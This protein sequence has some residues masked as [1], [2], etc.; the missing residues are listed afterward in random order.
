MA[1]DAPRD[2][3]PAIDGPARV[4]LDPRGS[5]GS[6]LF[7]LTVAPDQARPGRRD[8]T[9]D[10]DRLGRLDGGQPGR[11]DEQRRQ[12]VRV[13]LRD[14]HVG[15][16]DLLDEFACDRIQ[17]RQF[18]LHRLVVGEDVPT[19]HGCG[20]PAAR[21]IA[22]RAGMRRFGEHAQS[23]PGKT[24]GGLLDRGD[25]VLLVDVVEEELERVVRRGGGDDGEQSVSVR[26]VIGPEGQERKE[27]A[28]DA[29]EGGPQ[30]CGFLKDLAYVHRAPRDG[31]EGGYLLRRRD[32]AERQPRGHVIHPRPPAAVGEVGLDPVG[33]LRHQ[34][35]GERTR[36]RVGQRRGGPGR[37]IACQD[38][39]DL[40]VVL[41]AR[42]HQMPPQTDREVETPPRF[43]NLLITGTL[44]HEAP[45]VP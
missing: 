16:A 7:S 39:A 12:R 41:L 21:R 42:R 23:A 36:K 34:E 25:V 11:A 3:V 9:G 13:R 32:R 19:Q 44:A 45:R 40:R 5:P 2:V 26:Q 30:R 27:T 35:G 17:V 18:G 14:G 4:F 43:G 8:Q 33:V 1:G 28:A 37:P 24:L 20:D 29:V 10:D 22:E 15:R 31:G 6:P 38:L